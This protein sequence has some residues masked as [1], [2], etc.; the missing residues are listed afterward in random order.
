MSSYGLTLFL[1]FL[2]TPIV[3]LSAYVQSGS[4]K[5]SNES[6]E[7]NKYLSKPES[8]AEIPYHASFEHGNKTTIILSSTT[9]PINSTTEN[10]NTTNQVITTTPLPTNSTTK[11]STTFV[12]SN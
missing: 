9:I 2:V 8:N 1:V 4:V 7:V 5:G 12:T 6:I 11:E 3:T 10:G